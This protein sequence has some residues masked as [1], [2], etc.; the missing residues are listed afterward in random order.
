MDE[1]QNNDDHATKRSSLP[2]QSPVPSHS[3]ENPKDQGK[4]KAG[5]YSEIT[6]KSLRRLYALIIDDDKAITHTFSRA[7]QKIGYRCDQAN[8]AKEALNRLALS[9]PDL[10]LLDLR[11]G[12]EIDGEDILLQIRTNPRLDQTSVIVISAYPEM[13]PLVAELADLVIVKPVDVEQLQKLSARMTSYRAEPEKLHITDPVTGLYNRNF[14]YKRLEHAMER[15]RRRPDFIFAA[16]ALRVDPQYIPN[17]EPEIGYSKPFLRAV[18]QRLQPSLRPTDTTAFLYDKTFATLLED[19]RYPHDIQVVIERIENTI[20]HPYQIQDKTFQLSYNLGA[21]VHD[22]GYKE[23][24]EIL[25]TAEETMKLAH[26]SRKNCH[27][28][29]PA[30]GGDPLEHMPPLN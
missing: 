27:L 10:V 1:F 17:G 11:I 4:A 25:H 16:L 22:K 12:H 14:F 5:S 28:I 29:V 7:L 30:F 15:A 23:P 13:A 21:V 18:A 26:Q 24:S 8:S 6:Q 3:I 19:L 20:A 9:E 2:T